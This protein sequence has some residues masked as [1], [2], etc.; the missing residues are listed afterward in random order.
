MDSSNVEALKRVYAHVN[1]IDVYTGIIL[2]KPS[3]GAAIG[4]TGGYVIA[5]Q[6][7]ALK[8]G[9]RF[10][11]EHQMEWSLGAYFCEYPFNPKTTRSMKELLLVGLKSGHQ[12]SSKQW[13]RQIYAVQRSFAGALMHTIARSCAGEDNGKEVTCQ[14]S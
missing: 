5:E 1:D 6:F 13:R 12:N 8:K 9:D 4:P 2:E 7:T 11:Y 3:V 14:F 10:F